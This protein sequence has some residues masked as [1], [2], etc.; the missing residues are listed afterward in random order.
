MVLELVD[1]APVCQRLIDELRKRSPQRQLVLEMESS[2]PLLGDKT[3][4]ITALDCL[5]DNA[6][7]F[8]AKKE[9][10]WIKVGLLPGKS[11]GDTVLC[12]SDNGA[13]FDAAFADRL[14]APFQRLH[15]SADYAGAGLGLAIV[16]RIAQRH[17]GAVWAAS[18]EQAGASFFISLP[19]VSAYR[20]ALAAADPSALR[21]AIES[22]KQS[23]DP[24]LS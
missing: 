9:Q 16:K 12:V 5:I 19:Q 7:K 8:S 11:A 4:L 14:F 6:W 21:P 2:L 20:L 10:G 13:G 18:S 24:W 17:G 1:L 22:E 23:H 3:M 15:S